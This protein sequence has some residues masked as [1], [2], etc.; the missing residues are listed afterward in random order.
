MIIGNQEAK[1]RFQK[2]L[3][4][5]AVSESG[6]ASFFLLY[7][8]A[9]IGKSAIALEFSQIYLGLYVQWWLLNIRDFTDI[10]GKKHSIKIEENNTT[11]EYKIL[12]ND[13]QYQDIWVRQ[14]NNWLQQ[15]AF[16]WSKILLIENIER[17]TR[18]A[19]N[20]FLKAC[21]EPLPN[22]IIIATTSNKSKI[23]DTIISRAIAIPFSK[24]SD[25]EM[26]QY[27][28]QNNIDINSSEV[29]ELI[30]KMAM[31]KPWTLEKFVIQ[32]VADEKRQKDIQELIRIL[33]IQGKIVEKFNIL[34]TF[35]EQWIL[36][37]FLDGWI[38]YCA[39]HH[40]NQAS[41]RLKV[42]RL[43]QWNIQKE[44]VILYWLLYQ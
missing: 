12:Y 20:A 39:D 24:L 38:A 26:N 5:H 2:Y 35:K 44:N 14:I 16:G 4:Q 37:Q 6:Q 1:N 17:M 9:N 19:T 42:K 21:E 28:K 18:E 7:G 40:I 22:R 33:P 8:P 41:K 43:L 29:K 31:G 36:E 13:Y 34:S 11:E 10:L 15:S 25:D 3:E 27:I 23:L 30:I 32:F